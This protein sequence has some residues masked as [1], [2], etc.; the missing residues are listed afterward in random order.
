MKF[1]EFFFWCSVGQHYVRRGSEVIRE[2]DG[3]LVCPDH[4]KVLR[5]KGRRY[6]HRRRKI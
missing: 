1:Y 6:G 4:L 3:K 2:S 5:T